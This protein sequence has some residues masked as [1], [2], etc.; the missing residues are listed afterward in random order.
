MEWDRIVDGWAAMTLRLRCG[1]VE[2]TQVPRDPQTVGGATVTKD[3]A[4]TMTFEPLSRQQ[5]SSL[6][7]L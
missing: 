3:I 7:D 1:C 6:R 4:T 5:G 2:G